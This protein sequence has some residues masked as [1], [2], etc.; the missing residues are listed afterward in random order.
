L[1]GADIIRD[2]NYG[3]DL[4]GLSDGIGFD[5][6]TITQGNGAAIINYQGQDIGSV[7]GATPSQLEA[8]FFTAI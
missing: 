3:Q 1:G 5:D 4:I 8:S 7:S 2:F 6:L